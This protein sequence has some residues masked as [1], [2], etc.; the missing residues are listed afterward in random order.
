MCTGPQGAVTINANV[1]A[2]PGCVLNGTTVTKN[3]YLLPNG[4]LHTAGATVGGDIKIIKTAG[5]NAVCRAPDV[6]G[7][8]VVNGNTGSTTLGGGACANGNQSRGIQ[9][10]SNT[11]PVDVDSSQVELDMSIIKNTTAA[12]ITLSDTAVGRDLD[13]HGNS[14][15]AEIAG[16]TTVDGQMKGDECA[17]HAETQCPATGCG[18]GATDGT[19]SVTVAVPGGG[20][21][22]QLKLAIS[23]PPTDDGCLEGSSVPVG[24]VVTVVPPG[25]HKATNPIVI[26]IEWPFTGAQ[27]GVCKSKKGKRPFNGLPECI[28]VGPPQNV[29]CWTEDVSPQTVQVYIKSN[30]PAFSGH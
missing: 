26:T 5:S 3:V 25:G 9:I 6:G 23:A 16:S 13:C 19:T 1:N 14:P 8:I 17:T 24:S 18:L 15:D 11:G 10:T 2:G 20:K 27:T 12:P 29:P 30:D 21:Q 7:T 4:D 28:F 22:G